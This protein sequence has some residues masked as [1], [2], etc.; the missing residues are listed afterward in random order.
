M[1][2]SKFDLHTIYRDHM[3]PQDKMTKKLA[4]LSWGSFSGYF[5]DFLD[6]TK[7]N[8]QNKYHI[9]ILVTALINFRKNQ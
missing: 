5:D 6:L 9:F 7:S 4:T 2:Y 3:E 8:Q 1:D